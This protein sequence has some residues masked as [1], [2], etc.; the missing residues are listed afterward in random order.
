M[1]TEK[2]TPQPMTSQTRE[3]RESERTE[4]DLLFC[5]HSIGFAIGKAHGGGERGKG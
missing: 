1:S 5:I 4:V 3:E 2:R